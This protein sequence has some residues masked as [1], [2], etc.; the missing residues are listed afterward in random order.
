MY[1]KLLILRPLYNAGIIGILLKFEINLHV[2]N[3][4]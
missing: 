4:F 2:Y 3:A 1:A